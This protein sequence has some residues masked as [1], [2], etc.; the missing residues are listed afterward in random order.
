MGPEGK[1]KLD[2]AWIQPYFDVDGHPSFTSDGKYML[3]DSYP[4]DQNNRRY[5][6]YNTENGKGIVVARMPENSLTNNASCDLHPKLSRGNDYVAFD[7]TESAKH[8]MVL[9]KLNW[10][11]IREEIG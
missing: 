2:C 4:D 5:I 6:I 8:Q 3:T 11:S 7:T 1:Y 9:F 10:E